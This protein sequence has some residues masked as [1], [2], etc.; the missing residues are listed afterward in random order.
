M[1]KKV[2][3]SIQNDTISAYQ[4]FQLLR[5]TSL[6]L[7]SILLVKKGANTEDMSTYEWIFFLGNA[8][9]FF[10]SMGLKNGLLNFYPKLSP[11]EQPNF[12]KT[13]ILGMFGLS[14]I[15]GLTAGIMGSTNLIATS[16]FTLPLVLYIVFG[17]SSTS[18]EHIFLVKNKARS[19]FTFATISHITFL[20]LI[21][22][23]YLSYQI[24]GAIWGLVSW[25]FLKFFYLLI[26][27]FNQAG[28]I[29]WQSYKVF[30][31][32]AFPLMIQLF[33]GNGME[34]V[35][36]FLVKYFFSEDQ[37]AIFR[38]GARELPLNSVLITSLSIASIPLAMQNLQ[39]TLSNI[40]E[41]LSKL[42]DILFPL[43]ILL[44]LSSEY[45]FS[46]FYTDEYQPSA[47]I[48]NIY[49]VIIISRILLPQVIVLAHQDNRLMMK[50][51]IAEFCINIVLSIIF[52]QY[53]G[54]AGIAIATLIAYLFEKVVLI[55]FVR[56]KYEIKLNQ[57]LPL[58][59]YMIYTGM[60]LLVFVILVQWQ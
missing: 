7:I 22:I 4:Y 3:H 2:V 59:K 17:V 40:R 18:I 44:M 29:V 30:L 35:D 60:I 54:L 10:W 31:I 19:I 12:I 16:S 24:E 53:W 9:S 42:M 41:R 46:L 47:M 25:T 28:R 33:L 48:F 57:Y 5:L 32:F 23:G 1:L 13:F 36:G 27:Y 43:S 11:D 20:V 58:K 50:V 37:F 55:Y 45:L 21:Y 52:M 15:A 6:I 14:L 26:F 8:F 34:Y 49:L 51:A 39:S 56:K 38:Y